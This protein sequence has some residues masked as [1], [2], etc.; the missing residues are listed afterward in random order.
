MSFTYKNPISNIQ[1]FEAESVD[2][3]N[4]IGTN[5]SVLQVGGYQEVFYLND[6]KLTFLGTGPQLLSA[7]TIPIQIIVN[8]NVAFDWT[9]LTLNSDNI[10]SGRRRL[11][12]LV[13]VHETDTVYQ[14]YIPDYVQQWNTLTGLTGSS[15]IT[16]DTTYTQ[17]N[18]RSQA[19]RDFISLWTGSTI[20]GVSGVTRNNA[21]WRI[22]QTATATGATEDVEYV[23]INCVP[24]S[25]DV[26]AYTVTNNFRDTFVTIPPSF[27]DKVIFSITASYGDLTSNLLSE[28]AV[29]L[30]NSGN[31]V[32]NSRSWFHPNNIR[33]FNTGFT[34]P[35]ILSANCTMNIAT[36]LELNNCNCILLNNTSDY[37]LTAYYTGCSFPYEFSPSILPNRNTSF[38][39]VGSQL[40]L[41]ADGGTTW[42]YSSNPSWGGYAALSGDC[43]TIGS[44]DVCGNSPPLGGRGYSVTLKI[45]G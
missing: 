4:F 14:Y 22:F 39:I 18:A 32:V 23:G 1:R 35:L 17:I 12:M 7:N 34:Q 27:A 13:Y 36:P 10:S 5:F 6:L 28:F 26:S 45:S 16:Q 24:G 21:R 15:A 9:I 2:R 30:R 31:T 29:E 11:G 33:I 19:G 42:T 8:P 25:V 41:E 37:I 38:C 43:Y 20:E 3:T 44:T 40:I